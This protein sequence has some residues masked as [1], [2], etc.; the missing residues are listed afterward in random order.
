MAPYIN[1]YGTPVQQPFQGHTGSYNQFSPNVPHMQS[2][3][4]QGF[5]QV[6]TPD[7]PY[8]STQQLPL[9]LHYG[10]TQL[11]D[12]RDVVSRTGCYAQLKGLTRLVGTQGRRGRLPTSQGFNE[13]PESLK[14]FKPVLGPDGRIHCPSC[15]K[16][17]RQRKHLNRH[18][19]RHLGLRPYNCAICGAS[20]DRS[21]SRKRHQK[22]CAKRGMPFRSAGYHMPP[23]S[24]NKTQDGRVSEPAL[25]TGSH[26][27]S[28]DPAHGEMG[29]T[30]SDKIDYQQ[31]TTHPRNGHTSPTQPSIDSTEPQPTP[32]NGSGDIGGNDD[33]FYTTPKAVLSIEKQRSVVG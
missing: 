29:S 2:Q 27:V 25:Q 26:S 24:G 17:Y 4:S 15:P 30:L 21:D 5:H 20:F 32:K 16:T 11:R 6:H 13:P 14:S 18:N 22:S 31:R 9:P 28:L 33:E 10:S 19:L 12:T 1:G 7:G 23:G 3:N 8:T